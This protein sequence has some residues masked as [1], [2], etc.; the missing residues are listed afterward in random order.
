MLLSK[1]LKKCKTLLNYQQISEGNL[2]FFHFLLMITKLFGLKP[3]WVSFFCLYN[4]IGNHHVIPRF[5]TRFEFFKILLALFTDFEAKRGL[6]R[7]RK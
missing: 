1:Q 5:F 4:R 6:N 2:Q 3:F 7:S